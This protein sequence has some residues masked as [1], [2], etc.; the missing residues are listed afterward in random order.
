M[1]QIAIKAFKK[2]KVKNAKLHIVGDGSYLGTIKEL[3]KDDDRIII[4]GYISDDELNQ[5]LQKSSYR[6][7][8]LIFITTI[9]IIV[10]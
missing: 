3:A 2:L 1:P 6:K 9:D 10:K 8:F 7:L 5:L 4:H